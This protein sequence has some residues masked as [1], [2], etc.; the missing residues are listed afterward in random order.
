MVAGLEAAVE[1]DEER[2]SGRVDHLKDPFLT[3]ETVE[4]NEICTV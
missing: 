2:V 3:H 4:Q 1:A